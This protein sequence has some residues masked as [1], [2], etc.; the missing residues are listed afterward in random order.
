MCLLSHFDRMCV[1]MAD[2]DFTLGIFTIPAGRSIPLHDHPGMTVI[3]RLLFGSLRVQVGGW[4][5]LVLQGEGCHW[6][7]GTQMLRLLLF[8]LLSADTAPIYCAH[9]RRMTS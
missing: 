6:M 1:H 9:C 3:S 2:E 4:G 5:R 7:Q 8:L